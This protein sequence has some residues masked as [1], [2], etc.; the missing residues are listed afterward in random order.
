M[1][2]PFEPQVRALRRGVIARPA[3]AALAG[4]LAIAFSAIFYRLADVSPSTGAFFRCALALPLLWLLARREDAHLGRRSR[5]ARGFAWVAGAFFA[6]DLLLWHHA[7]EAVGAGL[8]TVLANMQVAVFGL[9]AWLAFRE[10]PAAPS[11]AAVPLA[12]VGI[13]LIS[14]ILESDAY[15]ESPGLGAVL[16]V[17]AGLAYCGVLVTLRYGAPDV[18]R[19]AGPLFDVTLVAA[20][21]ALPGG[22]A[23]GELDLAPPA[24]AALWLALLALTSQVFGWLLISVSLA[25]LPAI[26]T[27]ILLTLQPV[28]SVVFAAVLLGERPSPLQLLGTLAILAGLV[29]G[30]ADRTRAAP[31]ASEVRAPAG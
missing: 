26:V 3:P 31:Q 19:V 30:S 5:R 22:L 20:L 14:G 18:R 21:L 23:L 4:A 11:L 8:A 10:R 7:I 9:I 1:S 12:V 13:V 29:V 24:A 6:V 16:G 15:G 27:S 28:G 2:P 17:L 25:R